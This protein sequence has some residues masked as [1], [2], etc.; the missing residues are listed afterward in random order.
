M[1]VTFNIESGKIL[2]CAVQ[3]T[4][5]SFPID[6]VLGEKFIMGTESMGNYVI[7]YRD[8]GYK[9][10]KHGVLENVKETN[11]IKTKTIINKDIYK[12][13]I[14]NENHFG[15]L[16]RLLLAQGK[17]QFIIDKN[18]EDTLK[19]IVSEHNQKIHTFY[20]CRGNDVALL[21]KTFEINL[22]DLMIQKIISI[23]YAPTYAV[24]IY[25][26]KIFDYSLERIYE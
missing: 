25:C 6:V 3:K 13:P 2:G 11:K 16:I 18:F 15:I 19:L 5:N 10:C 9:L 12:V 26:K 24:N 22:Y 1:Y 21:D 4:D 17:I 8:G 23:D 20:S 14:K 7:K